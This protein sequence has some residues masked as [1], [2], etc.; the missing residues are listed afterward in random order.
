MDAEQVRVRGQRFLKRRK[1][2]ALIAQRR[3]EKV[4]R[5]QS[6]VQKHDTPRRLLKG[7]I[8]NRRADVGGRF[9]G[10]DVLVQG[11]PLDGREPPG[12]VLASRKRQR[13]KFGPS[14]GLQVLE[15]RG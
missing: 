13:L 12:L 3:I 15:P 5:Y 2:D 1:N 7:P 6:V 8:P 10:K 14:G 9:R 11:E 4:N